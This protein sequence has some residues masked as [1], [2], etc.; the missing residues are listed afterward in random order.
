MKKNFYP[1]LLVLITFLICLLNYKP[2]TWLSGWD[3]LHPEFNFSLNFKR[4]FFGVWREDQGLGAVAGHSHMA[5]LPRVLVLWLFSFILPVSFLRYFYI[6]LCLILGPLG[7]YFFIK[8]TL[9]ESL[10]IGG[11]PSEASG[12]AFLGA[13]F[14]LFNLGTLQHFYVPFEMFT[15]QYAALGWLFLFATKFLENGKRKDLLVFSLATF[16]TTPQAYAST[17]FYVYFL[18]LGIYLLFLSF[19][20]KKFL[21]LKR[22]FFVLFIIFLV[23][24][25]WILPNLYFL[26]TSAKNV[27][28][29]KINLLFSEEAFLKNKKYGTIQDT[30]ILKNFLFS[31]LKVENGQFVY[32]LRTWL[33]YFEQYPYLSLVGY[34]AF[35]FVLLGIFLGFVKSKWKYLLAFF[36]VF[37]LCFFFIL[38]ADLQIFLLKEALRMPFTKFSLVLMLVYSVY[39]TKASE[40][41]GEKLAK[42]KNF[43]VVFW[44][45]LFVI[46]CS[47]YFK[48][49]LISPAMKVKIP[50]EYFQVFE[51][52]D[53]QKNLGRIANFHSPVYSGWEYYSW[54]FQGAGFFWFGEKMPLLTRDFDRWNPAN[55]NY[56]HEVSY[57]LYSKNLPLFEKVLEKYQ[58]NWLL[59]D[60]N[61]V[62]YT[63]PKSLYLDE[64]E[65]LISKSS[66][67]SLATQFGKIKI[68]Q[69]DLETKPKDFVFLTQNLPKVEPVYKWNNFDKAYYDYGNYLS[70]LFSFGRGF[71]E[72]GDIQQ[73]ENNQKQG[74]SNDD[75]NIKIGPVDHDDFWSKTTAIIKETIPANVFAV[76]NQNFFG[77]SVTR[78]FGKINTEPNQPAAKFV[79][80]PDNVLSQ[81]VEKEGFIR[82][83]VSELNSESQYIYYPFRSL[84]TGRRQEE[85]EFKVKEEG[86]N[87]VFW[88]TVPKEFEDG[89]MEIASGTAELVE[90]N[91][92]NLGEQKE[93]WPEVNLQKGIIEVKFPKI[94]GIYSYDSSM[95]K[96]WLGKQPQSCDAFN[97]GQ[98]GLEKIKI[99]DQEGWRL[100]ALDQASCLDL[101][102]PTLEN[103]Y[104]Y[105]ITVESR[106][107][108]GKSLL[109]WLEN[110]QS[111]KA[112]IETYLP[113][114]S[115]FDKSYFIQPPMAQDGLGY[116]LHF[117]NISIGRVKSV[118]DLVRITINPIPYK[119]LTS[120]NVVKNKISN[121]QLTIN[122]QFTVSHP[123]ESFYKV[124]I[125]NTEPLLPNTY[126]I[127]S[128]SFSKDWLA[129][130]VQ[131]SKFKVQSLPKVLVNNWENGWQ[132]NQSAVSNQQLTIYLFF[133]PQLLEYFGFLLLLATPLVILKYGDKTLQYSHQKS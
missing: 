68:Y 106:Y 63:S 81:E 37:L 57:A 70:S 85:L 100:S 11:P 96:D 125:P 43:L 60:G 80:N 124:E 61:V 30:A 87:F 16:L 84:F 45:I 129:F 102:L 26:K 25:F 127:L 83:N 54:G 59:V 79:N 9:E 92:E 115:T 46:F 47:P 86:N 49:E 73:K 114:I 64:L 97:K 12:G 52:F 90:I 78:K 53:K 116:S 14:Y 23:N 122:N 91:P 112:D 18:M 98:F 50:Q 104:S 44:L 126:L 19:F 36:P 29:A 56:Y 58:I 34:L 123:N 108:K 31:W 42:I 88:A 39:F 10:R 40:W 99:G 65:E 75:F 118:N 95:D 51:W 121:Q 35:S 130:Q 111:R 55:E 101:Y 62:S 21:F 120:L 107:Q 110:L 117:N 76:N 103:R 132:L 67:I 2:G 5:D 128:Q 1:L 119:F 71:F 72:E 8:Y 77:K 3:T 133:W 7:V 22:S 17:L 82:S 41:L 15:V 74:I 24:S 69:V 33:E 20:S 48:G 13:L 28:E 113:K 131:S 6:F 32:L 27:P 94:R 4:L 105:L 38:G 89:K 109:F 93:F 66:K